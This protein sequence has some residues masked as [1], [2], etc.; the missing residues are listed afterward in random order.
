MNSFM[1]FCV[2][3]CSKSG[4]QK[5]VLALV[6]AFA[7]AF[8]MFAGAAFTD[9]ADI[10]ADNADA[11]ELLTTLGI[12]KGY[13]DGSF[14]PEGVVTRAEMAKMIYTIRNGGNDDASAYETVTTSFTDINGHWAEGYIKYL[15]N[16][17][18]VAGK[19]ATK[20]DPNSQVTTGEAMKMALALAGYD[21]ENAGLTG[22]AWLNNTVSYATTYGLTEDVH[23]AIAAGCTRQDAAQILSNCL[24]DVIA[25]R[26]SAIVENFVNDSENGLS[27]GGNPITVGE[28][29]MDLKVDTGFI[30]AAP[31]SKTNPKRIV[32]VGEDEGQVVFRDSAL[33]VSDMLGYEVKVVWNDEKKNDADAI[34][35]VYKT[36]DNTSYEAVWKDIEADGNNKVK[37][38]DQT[39]EFDKNGIKVYADKDVLTWNAAEFNEDALSDTV[40]FID[41]DGDGKIEA[42]Q[43]KTQDVTKI[44]YVGNDVIDTNGLLADGR[45]NDNKYEGVFDDTGAAG[46][47]T[48]DPDLKDVNVY[49]GIA[50][51]DYAKVSYDYYNDK[52][53]YEKIDAVEAKVEATRTNQ[54]TKEIRIDGTWYKAAEGYT[55][56]SMLSGDSIEYIAIGTLL[57]NVEKLDG[58]WGSKNL[59][60]VYDVE[61]STSGLNKGDLE[62]GLITRNGDKITGVLDEY[63]NKDVTYTDTDGDGNVQNTDNWSIDG[64]SQ[65]V[66]AMKNKTAGALVGNLVLYRQNGNDISLMP[67]STTQMAGYNDYYLLNT[68][69]AFNSTTD[70]VSAQRNGTGT[71]SNRNIADDAVVF[72]WTDGG[73]AEVIS[74]KE[75]KN[76][77]GATNYTSIDDAYALGND[78]NGVNYVQALAL[79]VDVMPT[80]AAS[81]Y[82]YVLWAAEN[83]SDIDGKDYREFSLWTANGE[84]TAYE[85]TSALYEYE[86]GEIVKFENV[87]NT[88]GRMVIDDVTPL[89]VYKLGAIT[90]EDFDGKTVAIDWASYDLASDVVMLNVDTEKQVG[91]ETPAADVI[92]AAK[93][94]TKN[95]IYVTNDKNEIEF[96]L[97]DG[98]NNEIKTVNTIAGGS[99]A[100]ADLGFATYNYVVVDGALNMTDALD[101]DLGKS[102]TVNGNVDLYNAASNNT[103]DGV[104]VVN[105]NLDMD[106][107][108]NL[109]VEGTL[110]ITGS[111]TGYTAGYNM[112]SGDGDIK[113]GNNDEVS[114]DTYE[115]NAK[116]MA[117][118][119]TALDAAIGTPA[120]MGTPSTSLTGAVDPAA[121]STEYKLATLAAQTGVTITAERNSS[122]TGDDAAALVESVRYDAASGELKFKTSS[123]Y[124][125]TNLNGKKIGV[126]ITVSAAGLDD[127]VYYALVT[128]SADA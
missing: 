93:S 25:V 34:Y 47:Y 78:V 110:I 8:T 55:L 107:V 1:R 80:V 53:T 77:T 12:I 21:E 115:T 40:V 51:N 123:T 61:P 28:K 37:F 45:A 112:I 10:N 65:A 71:D 95:I 122:V 81:N 59:A 69:S 39:V 116:A 79:N 16:T 68:A 117:D 3:I 17:G 24:I 74:G 54:G 26:Y 6:L 100:N 124:N 121:A 67:V 52:V 58:I 119:K 105:G 2:A 19:S 27:W 108:A 126:E 128:V 38:D 104:V 83:I 30:T 109:N 84:V 106:G 127:V 82:A 114:A 86:G 62:I 15:Q 29:W 120:T 7:C 50:K 46:D 11:V 36:D 57:Y 72:L 56:P 102:L 22:P 49:E 87:S 76:A 64:N 91:L 44:T 41:N 14:D 88:D 90:T 9:A 20:F 48:T 31:S 75:L 18:I 73:D 33:D 101:V 113:V 89:A 99:K 4:H 94:G 70:V 23:S 35:G 96:L 66:A 118:A 111:L 98:K 43:V 5:K 97:V 92:R 60:I 32:F 63:N 103:I 125:N 13:E 42:A 85:Q